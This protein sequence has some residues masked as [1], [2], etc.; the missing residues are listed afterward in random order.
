MKYYIDEE[1]DSKNDNAWIKLLDR[2]FPVGD[3]VEFNVLNNDEQLKHILDKFEADIIE[4]GFRKDKIYPRGKFV[5][6]EISSSIKEFIYSKRYK[7]W[8]GFCLEDISILKDGK[9]ILATI[10]HENYIYI[11]GTS[12]QVDEINSLGFQFGRPFDLKTN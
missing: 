5:R 10:T 4:I 2:F 6:F 7:S 3:A 11:M 12:S 9:E 8:K 1:F